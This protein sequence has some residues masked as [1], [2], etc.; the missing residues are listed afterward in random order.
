MTRKSGPHSE[1]VLKQGP[2]RQQI[3]RQVFGSFQGGST[4]LECD[5][6]LL[7]VQTNIYWI[8]TTYWLGLYTEAA[9]PTLNALTLWG[10]GWTQDRKWHTAV[11]TVI[12]PRIFLLPFCFFKSKQPQHRVETN[13]KIKNQILSPLWY[14]HVTRC[15]DA[16]D[17]RTWR[18][19]N[20]N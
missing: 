12:P 10:K 15:I 1:A 8:I 20:L 19:D 7:L 11:S 6:I 13:I 5:F 2:W 14:S 9:F 4:S 3:K 17:A 18:K 16:L